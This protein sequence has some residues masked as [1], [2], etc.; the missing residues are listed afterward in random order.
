M[1]EKDTASPVRSKRTTWIKWITPDEGIWT[2]AAYVAVTALSFLAAASLSKSWSA[3]SDLKR[4]SEHLDSVA[5]RLETAATLSSRA[6]GPITAG[7]PSTTDLPASTGAI[8]PVWFGTNRRPA[9]GNDPAKGFTT[10]TDSETRYGRVDVLV[11]RSHRFGEIGNG[12]FKRLLRFD[13][14][15]D[16]LSVERINPL[17]EAEM[18]MQVQ[19]EVERANAAGNTSQAL[20]FIHG[21]NNSFTDAAIRAAQI[22][23]DLKVAGATAFFSWPSKGLT[24]AYA[25]DAATIEASESAI[26][27]FIVD[28]AKESRAQ[29]LHLVAHSMGNRGLLRSLQRIAADAEKRSVVHFNQIFLAAPDVD[30]RLFLDLAHLY[31]TFAGRTTLYASSRDLPI[32]LSATLHE[33]PRAGYFLPYTVVKGIDTIAV[34]NFNVDALGHGY[35]AQAEALLHD[36]HDLMRADAPPQS[37]QRIE[38]LVDGN[39]S[40]WQF[41]R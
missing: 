9:D 3:A 13:L 17:A 40:L 7:T 18:W 38:P 10:D 23:F 22:G 24:Q 2:L 30:R 21:Y 37:R 16:R 41:R 6:I 36:I 35:F 32:Y 8:Y 14:R 20:L 5:D 28:F 33:S 27:Q 29:T 12:F 1:S 25:A 34:P 26:T 15:D 4:T 11:P 31:P 39:D 19:K